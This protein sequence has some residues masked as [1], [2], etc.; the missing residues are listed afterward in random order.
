MTREYLEIL[1]IVVVM[2]LILGGIVIGA[3]IKAQYDCSLYQSIT[4]RPTMYKK[5]NECYVQHEDLTW[6]TQ[7]EYRFITVKK[8][9]E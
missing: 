9:I 7:D 1:A 8:G 6:Y 5:F 4:G 3:E 2:I